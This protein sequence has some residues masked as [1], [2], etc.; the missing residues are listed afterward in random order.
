[1]SDE[2]MFKNFD[3]IHT[4]QNPYPELCDIINRYGEA[5]VDYRAPYLDLF[6]FLAFIPKNDIK[7]VNITYSTNDPNGITL[8]GCDIVTNNGTIKFVENWCI[9]QDLRLSELISLFLQPLYLTGLKG[10]V[11]FNDEKILSNKDKH[12]IIKK[13]ILKAEEINPRQ[14]HR[15]GITSKQDMERYIKILTIAESISDSFFD[16]DNIETTNTF[17]LNN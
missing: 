17:E 16:S 10:V 8:F 6:S 14:F 2:K 9:W 3:L 5:V 7:R 1:M 11:F 4:F 13:I 15:Q 12:K